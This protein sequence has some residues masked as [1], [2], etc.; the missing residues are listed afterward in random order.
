VPN[1]RPDDLHRPALPGVTPRTVRVA[2]VDHRDATPEA[3]EE[4]LARVQSALVTRLKQA[5]IEVLGE[6]TNDLTV[7][8]SHT[9]RVPEGFSRDGCIQM[10]G[11]L[12]L[13]RGS[14]VQASASGCF[15]WRHLLGFSLNSDPSNMFQTATNEMLAQLDEQLSKLPAPSAP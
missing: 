13:P 11:R 15:E 14:F 9:E 8:V 5:G 12:S 4:T 6:S 10:T 3:S 1:L 2:V 7:T